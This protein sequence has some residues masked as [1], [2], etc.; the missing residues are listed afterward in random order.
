EALGS[1]RP[2]LLGVEHFE[3]RRRRIAPEVHPELVDL[4][5]HEDRVLRPRA[6]QPLDDLA[7]QRADVGAPVATDLRLVADAAERDP[8]ELP[9][10][11]PRDRAAERRLA[12]AG[13][14][15]EAQDRVLARGPQLPDGE[16]LEDAP[17][18]P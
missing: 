3:Q 12:D 4:V 11:R 17:P 10:E 15:D 16:V 14:A 9:A 13:S 2:V 6:S 7:R 18:D 1:E 8:V 5:E